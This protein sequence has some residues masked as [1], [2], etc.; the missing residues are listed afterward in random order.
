MHKFTPKEHQ[1][2]FVK[3]F[4]QLCQSRQPWQVWA[5]F[6]MMFAI[7]I[8]NS[9]DKEQAEPR[10]RRYLE[11]AAGYQL[12]EQQLI[13]QLV[14]TTVEALD[15]NQ[16]QDFLGDLYMGLG[17]GNHWRG[18]FFTPYH[19]CQAMAEMSLADA[20]EHISRQGWM[21]ILDPACGAGATLIAAANTLR[22]AG[23]NYQERALFVGQDIDPVVAMMCYIQLSLLGCPGY[24]A[25][26]NSLTDPLT[27]NPLLPESRPGVDIWIT[28]VFFT[29]KWAM[30]RASVAAGAG[31]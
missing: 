28:P 2:A 31:A 7:A 6:V 1:K 11:L 4:D 9:L 14:T 26:G 10:E 22:R 24:V 8:S 13:T 23:I 3:I 17:M 5:D 12:K 25:V 18:Q 15:T 29:T 16:E 21:S 27:G 20:D 19:L 30:R